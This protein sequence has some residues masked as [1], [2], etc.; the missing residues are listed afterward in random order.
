MDSLLMD[1]SFNIIYRKGEEN[2]V[3]D[4][5]SHHHDDDQQRGQQQ[6]PQIPAAEGN[7]ETKMKKKTDATSRRKMEEWGE[8]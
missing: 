5:L 4:W 8:M 1:Y 2:I 3:A 6:Q 7:I